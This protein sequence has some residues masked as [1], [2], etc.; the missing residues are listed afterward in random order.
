MLLLVILI[1]ANQA[2]MKWCL[3]VILTLIAII[4]YGVEQ[5]DYHVYLQ[6]LLAMLH[7]I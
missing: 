6:L 5:V 1:L 2:G 3:I 4:I 7:S